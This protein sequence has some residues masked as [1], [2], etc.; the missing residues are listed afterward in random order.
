[1]SSAAATPISW[2]RSGTTERLHECLQDLILP[3]TCKALHCFAEFT[4]CPIRFGA[5]LAF[6]VCYR[7]RFMGILTGSRSPYHKTSFSAVVWYSQI[8][9]R[10]WVRHRTRYDTLGLGWVCMHRLRDSFE[11]NQMMHQCHTIS[12]LSQVCWHLALLVGAMPR[13]PVPVLGGRDDALNLGM[14]PRCDV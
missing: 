3:C 12:A 8:V 14:L 11:R 6:C 2:V 7:L 9:N 13:C 4:C 1:V 5:W 10:W